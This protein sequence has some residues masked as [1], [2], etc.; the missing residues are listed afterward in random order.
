MDL[1]TVAMSY[2]NVPRIH[3]AGNFQADP[4]TVNNNNANFDPTVQLKNEPANPDDPN[5]TSV[6]WNPF[7][8]HNWM[9][10]NCMVRG[11]VDDRGQFHGQGAD[12][13]VG[14]TVGSANPYPAKIVDLDPDNQAVS[15]IWGLRVTISIPN[16]GNDE[17]PLA[18]VTGTMPPTAF[19]DLW[20]RAKNH[21]IGMPT[22]SASYH[23]VL[24]DIVWDNAS[25][26]PVLAA[27]QKLSPNAL[28]IRF[29]LDS[30]Q[31]DSNQSNFTYGRVV[32]TLGPYAVGEA[33][34]STPRRLAPIFSGQPSINSA[35]GPVGVAWDA[36]RS[37]L[38]L[39]LGNSVPCDGT[40][41]T[42]G[43]SVPGAG[44]PIPPT[45]LGLS[46]GNVHSSMAHVKSG[47]EPAD[48]DGDGATSL[49]TITFDT[50][51]YLNRAGIVEV[52]VP[53]ALVSRIQSAPLTLV[54]AKSRA[55]VGQEDA[56]GRYVDVDIPFFRF[57]PG[58]TGTV[59]LWATRF[60]MPWKGAQLDLAL[61]PEVPASNGPQTNPLWLNNSPQS[62]LRIAGPGGS[63]A[64]SITV[65]TD[66]NGT[67]TV[68]LAAGDPGT[69]RKYPD[70]QDGPDGQVYQVVGSWTSWG[71]IFLYPGAAINVLVFSG[72]PVPAQPN[73]NEHVG[74]I[75]S[76]FARMYPYM[77]GIIDLGDY[78][79]VTDPDNLAAIA[80]VLNL[81]VTDSHH[82]PVTRDLSGGKLATINRWIKNGTPQS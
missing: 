62:A 18:S 71:Q 43:P 19:C 15:Q 3:F 59:T 47:V 10:A 8:T 69:P 1:R 41:P 12:P 6:Y 16:P 52:P 22:M 74:P 65:T 37:V 76:N 39:D 42:Q 24:Q 80:K 23:A 60:G 70:G 5:N 78:G 34:R 7:G 73:W 2:L 17:K 35:Y 40:P 55:P 81:P 49:G 26:S 53:A 58:D 61:A 25:A 56:Q 48:S 31:P 82:M 68:G 63:P 46:L 9:F 33:P 75:L 30:Y 57:N 72:Y 54:D 32:G 66:A 38:I 21:K 79:T 45:S 11:V 77:K 64:G 50:S 44:W 51:M 36:R 28:S 14:A 20:S 29:N 13:L 67:A 27:L 4:S